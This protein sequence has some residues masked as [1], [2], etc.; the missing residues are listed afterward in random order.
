M[1]V[2]STLECFSEQRRLIPSMMTASYHFRFVVDRALVGPK[3]VVKDLG[4]APASDAA[5]R[6]PGSEG[7]HT[8]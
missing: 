7:R 6:R 3:E 5:L 8:V 1:T 4:A 2:S